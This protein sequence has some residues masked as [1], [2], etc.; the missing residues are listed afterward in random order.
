M[1]AITDLKED[2]FPPGSVALR[3][4][5]D[6]HRIRFYGGQY[7]IVYQISYKRHLVIIKRVRP[8]ASAYQGL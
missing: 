3:G 6:L 2:A 4:H 1:D 5:Q 8:R 7:R